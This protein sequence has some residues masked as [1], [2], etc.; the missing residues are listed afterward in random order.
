[1]LV[2]K[3]VAPLL[4]WV[5]RGPQPT[6]MAPKR[7]VM[8]VFYKWVLQMIKDIHGSQ[9]ATEI[10]EQQ[11]TGDGCTAGCLLSLSPAVRAPVGPRGEAG[12]VWPPPP[13]G[14]TRLPARRKRGCALWSLCPAATHVFAETSAPTGMLRFWLP[15]AQAGSPRSPVGFYSEETTCGPYVLTVM[16]IQPRPEP[17]MRLGVVMAAHL[18]PRP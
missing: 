7:V 3:S 10:P 16:D 8:T 15:A 12:Q 13:R 4:T 11:V 6:N 1:M 17:Q 5:W 9:R 14:G 18:S 2:C